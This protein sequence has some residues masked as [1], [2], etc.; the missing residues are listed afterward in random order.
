[1]M[2]LVSL[3]F[4]GSSEIMLMYFSSLNEICVMYVLKNIRGRR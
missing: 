3:H 2:F 4:R 1:V